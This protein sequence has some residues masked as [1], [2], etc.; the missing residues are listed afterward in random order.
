MTTGL[1]SKMVTQAGP[2]AP[3]FLKGARAMA[4]LKASELLTLVGAG[5]MLPKLAML[6]AKDG[7]R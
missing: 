1:P 4:T 3:S 5:P 7:G 2:K 6:Q